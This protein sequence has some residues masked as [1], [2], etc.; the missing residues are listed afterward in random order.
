MYGENLEIDEEEIEY[1]L[2]KALGPRWGQVLKLIAVAEK[3]MT[4]QKIAEMSQMDQEHVSSSIE[5]FTKIGLFEKTS[6]G[7]KLTTDIKKIQTAIQRISVGNDG[8]AVQ[9]LF[10]ILE[11]MVKNKLKGTEA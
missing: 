7:Y 1:I 6:I 11:S 3:P 2:Y 4:A 10:V 5:F 8:A 9:R